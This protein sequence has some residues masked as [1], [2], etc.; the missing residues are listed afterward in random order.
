MSVLRFQYTEA[1]ARLD[2]RL[3]GL[4]EDEFLLGAGAPAPGLCTA[5]PMTEA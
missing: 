5:A 3:A 4:I 2:R 1:C